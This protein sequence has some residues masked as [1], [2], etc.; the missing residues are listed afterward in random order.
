MHRSKITAG[1]ERQG[2]PSPTGRRRPRWNRETIDKLLSNEKYV[3]DVL[4]QKI[5]IADLFSG[6]HVRN[7]VS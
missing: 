5:F 6:K 7:Q 3:G 4:L 1:L 2:I